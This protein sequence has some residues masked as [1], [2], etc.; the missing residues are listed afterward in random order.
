MPDCHTKR[1]LNLKTPES[2]PWIYE[3]WGSAKTFSF[4]KQVLILQN[5]TLTL[6]LTLPHVQALTHTHTHMWMEALQYT[7]VEL[8]L[9]IWGTA[10]LF[11][12]SESTL[13][14]LFLIC[15]WILDPL[16]F[17]PL[18]IRV[19]LTQ[20]VMSSLISV[21]MMPD[22]SVHNV[23]RQLLAAS[24]LELVWPVLEDDGVGECCSSNAMLKLSVVGVWYLSSKREKH[25]CLMLKRTTENNY[26]HTR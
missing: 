6:V 4:S 20:W 17:L 9:S 14:T 21:A 22:R 10:D 19:P 23:Q 12:A 1:N 24:W 11:Q 13:T 25:H 3:L 5:E 18:P 2:N 26:A 7:C 16:V 8:L 15:H